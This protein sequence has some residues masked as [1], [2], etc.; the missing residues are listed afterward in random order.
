MAAKASRG[1][2]CHGE[3]LNQPGKGI[4]CRSARQRRRYRRVPRPDRAWSRACTRGVDTEQISHADGEPGACPQRPCGGGGTA[5]C[6]QR[7]DRRGRA[8]S[9][10]AQRGPVARPARAADR[11]TAIDAR[12]A[13]PQP[14]GC[15]EPAQPTR[16]SGARHR[17]GNCPRGRGQRRRRAC[18]SRTC[19][20]PGAG[21]ARGTGP[22]GPE[23]AGADPAECDAARCGCIARP[24]AGGAG[25]HAADGAAGS[26]IEAPDAHEISLALPPTRAKLS[27]HR[28]V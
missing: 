25:A 23:F 8:G 5:G 3:W 11:A 27:A 20:G 19:G 24:A 9:N 28:A 18:R 7:S 16:R 2:S 13:R 26:A 17:R 4:A 6:R 21:P 15:A 14:P 1:G 10:R 12:P 22:V